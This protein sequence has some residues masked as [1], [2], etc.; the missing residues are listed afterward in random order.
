MKKEKITMS[1]HC[2]R[3]NAEI[4]DTIVFCPYCGYANV[5]KNHY[6]NSK[7]NNRLRIAAKVFMILGCIG[8][9]LCLKLAALAKTVIGA[10]LIMCIPLLWCIPMTIDYWKN[11][12]IV[13]VAFKICSLLFV[14]TIAGILMLCDNTTYNTIKK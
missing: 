2:K 3:C 14:S 7:T 1:K 13:G 4:D 11:C 5:A 10:I 6:N 9:P 12:D 8:S